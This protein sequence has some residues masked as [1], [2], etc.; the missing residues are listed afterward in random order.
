MFLRKPIESKETV[1]PLSSSHPSDRAAVIRYGSYN[2]DRQ[3][4]EPELTSSIALQGIRIAGI[5]HW[6]LFREKY[7]PSAPNADIPSL[8][9]L[10]WTGLA[11]SIAALPQS[12]EFLYSIGSHPQAGEQTEVS[13]IFWCIGR[14]ATPHEAQ[15]ACQ[16]DF[17]SLWKLLAANLDFIELQPIA[18]IPAHAIYITAL[19]NYLQAPH[20]IEL[21][22]R[23]QPVKISYSD[24]RTPISQ[25]FG[26]Q[27]EALSP[28]P[29]TTDS[30]LEVKH[31]FPWTASPDSW[32][33][34][35]EMF[36]QH[37]NCSI[38][39]HWQNF[40]KAP[41][42]A[43]AEAHL[44]TAMLETVIAANS[45]PRVEG[46]TILSGQTS[47]LRD[48][49]IQRQDYL[50]GNVLAARVFLTTPQPAPPA[51]VATIQSSID[52]SALPSSREK[53]DIP[54][55]GGM[56]S[57]ETT[58]TQIIAA[59]DQPSLEILFAP[60]EAAA[61]LRTPMPTN[62]ELPGI[63]SIRARTAPRIGKSGGDCLLGINRH[64]NKTSEVCLDHSLRF[65]HTYIIGQTGTGKST[66]ME[67]KILHDIEQGR[68]VA[69]L[70]PHGSLIQNILE[71]FPKHRADDLVLVDLTDVERPIGFNILCINESDPFHYRLARDLLIDD[72]YAYLDRTYD[73]KKTGGP[74]FESHFRSSLG[75]LLGSESQKAPRIPNLMILR[76]LYTNSDLRDFLI[77][78]ED[79]PV[80]LEF[81][82]E[83]DRAGGEASLENIA[84]YITS[85]F[86]RFISD[87]ALRN[88][89]CQSRTLDFNS[90]VNDGKVLL[91]NLGK[92]KFGAQAS[93]LLS[94]Q[95]VSRICNA[96]FKRGT[97]GKPFYLY[98]DEFQLFADER[99]AE[100][101]AEARKFKLSLTM[102]H[103]YVQQL[104][105]QVLSAVLGNVG[106]IVALRVGAVDGEALESLFSPTFG[107]RDLSSL[108]N[109][110][111]YVK[112]SGILGQT[113]FSID[114]PSPSVPRDPQFAA[115][116][117]EQSRQKYGIDRKKVESEILKTY[118]AYTEL[119]F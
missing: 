63:S 58:A 87:T 8:C 54:F 68:G 21:R 53:S 24:R 23:Y 26:F 64:G 30:D 96:A 110:C 44:N 32:Q 79:D 36:E 52:G 78:M 77:A 41:S 46:N 55:R 95:I 97:D 104:P 48:L 100:I 119:L 98:A 69:V 27:A 25:P 7:F 70:D 71:R 5:L 49:S 12:I 22:R 28:T 9:H 85:K 107:R 103:Q 6:E 50:C 4:V 88:I 76:A 99:F 86:S 92:G 34:L 90:I 59:F 81:T 14:G 20:V 89:T 80:L 116:L 42:T 37:V 112:S 16:R 117:R 114:L 51:M 67:Q 11:N 10:S 40:V 33:Q 72:I 113:P 38:V 102:A 47:I 13:S 115:K 15:L 62:T 29:N 60:A 56:Q 93:G 118:K 2:R 17:Q 83:A 91:V 73:L 39:M 74:I 66:L 57:I 105:S 82:K 31:L 101:L 61:I 94:S 84:P 3:E 108:P 111:A 19:H 109:F 1:H 65:R 43:L 18:N 75:L 45:L 35:L 106:T